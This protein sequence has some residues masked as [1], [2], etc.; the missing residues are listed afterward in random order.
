[1]TVKSFCKCEVL[2]NNSD[3][4]IVL[5]TVNN[6]R[7]VGK[8]ESMFYISWLPRFFNRKSP[9]SIKTFFYRLPHG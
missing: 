4:G 5:L 1:M 8:K 6:K 7:E 3:I 9:F 2:I